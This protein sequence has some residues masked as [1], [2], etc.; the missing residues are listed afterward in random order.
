VKAIQTVVE[1]GRKGGQ[2]KGPNK[3]RSREHYVE[4]GK[5]SAEARRLAR[6]SKRVRDET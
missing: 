5:K 1:A 3:A 2:A 6:H 4:M